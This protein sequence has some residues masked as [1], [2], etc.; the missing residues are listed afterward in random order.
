MFFRLIPQDSRV[1]GRPTK[2]HQFS[3]DQIFAAN[4]TQQE[5]F[6]EISQLV[7]SALDGY[8]VCIFAYGQTGS[9]KTYT[10]EGGKGDEEKG[11]IPRAV[12]QIFDSIADSNQK[13]WN[14]SV[15]ASFIEV[16][17]FSQESCQTDNL[18]FPTR[19]RISFSSRSTMR[20]FE[21]FSFHR[22]QLTRRSTRSSSPMVAQLYPIFRP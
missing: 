9:G 6:Q 5:V 1:K 20:R 11:M 3:F 4:S 13:G 7:Q 19:F 21:I 22:A 18:T 12:Q 16:C 8:N 17:R 10:M 15:A 2:S 14:Y